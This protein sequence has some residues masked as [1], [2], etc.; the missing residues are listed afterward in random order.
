MIRAQAGLAQAGRAG[1]QD[2]VQ[3]SPRRGG[4]LDRDVE[5]APSARAGRRTRPAAVAGATARPVVVL[6]DVRGLDALQVG[7]GVR[8]IGATPSGRG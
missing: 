8:I 2:V 3:R 1:E 5:L 4:R 7:A 6:A